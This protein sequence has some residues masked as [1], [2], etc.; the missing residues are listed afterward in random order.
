LGTVDNAATYAQQALTIQPRNP[1]VR[2]MIIRVLLAQRNFSKAKVEIASLQKEFPNA[3]PLLN[4][5]AA[6]EV[7]TRE[8][9]K[10]HASYSKAAEADRNNL[11]A[12]SGL[13]QIDLSNGQSK[14][15]IDRIEAALKSISPPTGDLLV[16]AS[17]THAAAGNAARAE[18]LLRQA[19]DLEPSRLDVYSR[20]AGLYL[21]QK[22]LDEAR[23]WFEKA[24]HRNPESIAANTMLAVVFA[25]QNRIADAER[26]YQKTLSIDSRAVIAANNLAWLYVSSNRNLDEA[27]RLA[28]VAVQQFP[29][30]AEFNDTLGWIYYKKNMSREAIRYLEASSRKAP[31]YA[32]AHYH[33]GMAY[34]QTGEIDWARK[35]LQ[36]ALSLKSDFEGADDARKTLARLG[37]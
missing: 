28:H 4:L 32:D 29:D 30:Q 6:Y 12:L 34:L 37:S 21:G 23:G 36:R 19:I 31:N 26:Q 18:D 16:L 25:L 33:L 10:A 17:A 2:A 8:I 1:E 27:L 5:V 3:A 9:G 22:R 35:E 24:V 15:A 14:A 7:A 11:E 20:L 13:V